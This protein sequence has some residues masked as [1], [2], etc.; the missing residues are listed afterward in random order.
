MFPSLVHDQPVAN[1]YSAL[2]RVKERS[3]VSFEP[4][5]LRRTAASMMAGAGVNWVV[6]GKILNH[7]EPGVTAVYDRHSYDPEKRIAL[8][9][10]G[11]RVSEIVKQEPLF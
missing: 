6:I 9:A 8:D 10:W 4:H 5:D 1:I 2:K 7:A 3:T 11:Q